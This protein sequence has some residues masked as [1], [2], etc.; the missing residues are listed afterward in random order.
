MR[1]VSMCS[2]GKVWELSTFPKKRGSQLLQQLLPTT[3]AHFLQSSLVGCSH[4]LLCIPHNL[5]KSL[6]WVAVNYGCTSLLSQH[7]PGGNHTSYPALVWCNLTSLPT[8]QERAG[9]CAAP[10]VGL[11][12]SWPGFWGDWV[13]EVI[14]W[15]I[16]HKSYIPDK[17]ETSYGSVY[18]L[19][20]PSPINPKTSTN[21]GFRLIQSC[22]I[23]LNL[24]RFLNDFMTHLLE[25]TYAINQEYGSLWSTRTGLTGSYRPEGDITHEVPGLVERK[26]GEMHWKGTL[27]FQKLI[28][29]SA[30]TLRKAFQPGNPGNATACALAAPH[31]SPSATAGSCSAPSAANSLKMNHYGSLNLQ[32][33]GSFFQ[34]QSSTSF[35]WLD[36]LY[37]AKSKYFTQ[38]CYEDIAT[39]GHS[40]RTRKDKES[41]TDLG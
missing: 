29:S 25:K 34:L 2:P 27:S 22:S 28:L 35:G 6:S 19:T 21:R 13:N 7:Q 17:L 10:G 9:S 32:N 1:T 4:I 30:G 16:S 11:A 5:G 40:K 26:P 12:P 24:S 37:R 39:F 36:Q 33:K 15:S 3:S 41:Q 18:L 31:L 14:C 8:S 20:E 23:E 38:R